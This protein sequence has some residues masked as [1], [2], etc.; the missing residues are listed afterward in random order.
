M[1][2]M[3]TPPSEPIAEP[4]DMP[5]NL[6]PSDPDAYTSPAIRTT[7]TQTFDRMPKLSELEAFVDH[8]LDNGIPGSA[9]VHVTA[10]T[11]ARESFVSMSTTD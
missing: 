9:T 6:A 5:V 1:D 2:N 7:F 3:S 11:S 10:S 8:L 4:A